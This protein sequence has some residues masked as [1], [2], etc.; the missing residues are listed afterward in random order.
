M[1]KGDRTAVQ[2]ANGKY[3][4][5][6]IAV[7]FEK[8][9]RNSAE[10]CAFV[11]HLKNAVYCGNDTPFVAA[12]PFESPVGGSIKWLW[13]SYLHGGAKANFSHQMEK[14][15]CLE[16]IPFVGLY[17]SG[18]EFITN[19]LQ[20]NSELFYNQ[21]R[22][23]R[24]SIHQPKAR[25]CFIV[26]G[27][28]QAI[29]SIDQSK[30]KC[31]S[32]RQNIQSK[33][34][35][36]VSRLYVRFS[37][38]TKFTIDLR[39]SAEF[40]VYLTRELSNTPYRE[41]KTAMDFVPRMKSFRVR[42]DGKRIISSD[43]WLH[44]LQTVS[45]VSESKAQKIMDYYPTIETLLRVYLDPSLEISMKENLLQDKMGINRQAA[46]SKRIYE[47]FSSRDPDRVIL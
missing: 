34:L 3:A 6:E 39:D 20:N 30:R 4:N 38:S 10:G 24:A 35:N 46:L 27:L 18:I 23:L 36:M 15:I 45:G 7:A 8:T 31:A 47:A 44:F 42:P 40:L 12:S 25:I 43:A 29:V 17:C 19:V 2:A 9:L 28:H 16:P 13:R 22:A 26:E 5:Q 1:K 41:R 11:E 33:I 32:T 21:I 14:Q 37:C